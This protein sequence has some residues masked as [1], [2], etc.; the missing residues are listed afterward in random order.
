MRSGKR[1][2]D[3]KGKSVK[4]KLKTARLTWFEH[5]MRMD[6]NKTVKV[7][8]E[9]VPG[10]KR[11]RRSSRTWYDEINDTV[12]RQEMKRKEMQNIGKLIIGNDRK[13]CR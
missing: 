4:Q 13:Q 2:K 10:E 5:G 6:E 3:L 7:I 11:R 8:C 1:R 12:R 9:M